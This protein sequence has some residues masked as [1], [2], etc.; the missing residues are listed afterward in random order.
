M[1]GTSNN[2][3]ITGLAVVVAVM[4]VVAAAFLIIN[5]KEDTGGTYEITSEQFLEGG[6]GSHVS[7]KTESGIRTVTLEKNSVYII[8]G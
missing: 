8:K 3:V 5:G 4:V 7:V 1:S 2:K 6:D